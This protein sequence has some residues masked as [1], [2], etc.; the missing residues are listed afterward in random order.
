MIS[1]ITFGLV[2]E[3]DT[4]KYI[5]EEDMEKLKNKELEEINY[6]DITLIFRYD[7]D[8]YVGVRTNIGLNNRYTKPDMK[9]NPGPRYIN[10]TQADRKIATDLSGAASY[11]KY[12]T[13]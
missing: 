2:R 5:S 13:R 7:E 9:I 1:F 4:Y 3:E 6:R 11:F 12:F 8:E 10:I